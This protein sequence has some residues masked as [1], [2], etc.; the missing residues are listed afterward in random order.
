M[1]TRRV[2]KLTEF[3]S[4]QVLSITTEELPPP[5]ADEVRI[6]QTAIGFNFIDIYQRKGI[7]PLP[8]PTGLAGC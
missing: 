1:V 2:V 6:R 7:Y 4:P 3:G 8:L 5:M